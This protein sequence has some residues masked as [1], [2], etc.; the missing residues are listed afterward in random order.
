[1]MN[2]HLKRA[3]ITTGSILGIAILLAG[4]YVGY[5][6]LSYNR[7]GNKTLKVEHNSS[8][9]EVQTGVEYKAL[10]YNIGFGA[11]SQDYTFFMDEGFDDEGRGTCGYYSTAK[12]E[13]EEVFN[14][15]GAITTALNQNADFYFFQEVDTNSTR[16]YHLNQDKEIMKTFPAYDHVHAVNFHTAFLPF[17][18][19]A[20]RSPFW[21]DHL[22]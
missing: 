4:G 10:S 8:I 22:I 20:W 3:L 1:M 7:I 2:K 14:T 21:Y 19:Y 9:P 6:M 15:V 16:S 17:I 11:Y 18:R 13:K 5:V 12:S